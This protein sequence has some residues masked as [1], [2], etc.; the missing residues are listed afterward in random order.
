M[1][2]A[3]TLLAAVVTALKAIPQLAAA[4]GG[5]G[6]I[7][8]AELHYPEL[9]DWERFVQEIE[10]PKIAVMWTGYRTGN[11]GRNESIKHDFRA[12]L[13]PNGKYSDAAYY[14]REGVPTISGGLKFKH[15]NVT[16]GVFPPE[17]MQCQMRS[18]SPI[19]DTF[20]DF[21]EVSFTLTE[22]GPDV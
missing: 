2:N 11:F 19:A 1:E 21:M 7:V 12:V 13:R 16:A 15:F 8:G 3:S 6:N 9:S 18:F 10:P 22:R 17:A 4:V 20:I 14:M 5:A